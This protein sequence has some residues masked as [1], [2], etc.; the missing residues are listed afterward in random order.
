MKIYVLDQDYSYQSI[1]PIKEQLFDQLEQLGK[2]LIKN[3]ESIELKV[4]E[5]KK[6]FPRS[7]FPNLLKYVPVFSQKAKECF[8]GLLRPLGE[9]LTVTIENEDYFAYN[10]TNII[11]GLDEEQS[12]VKR[13]V[14]SG[15]IMRIVKHEFVP[16]KVKEQ[17]MFKIPQDPGSIY[18]SDLFVEK[19]NQHELVGLKFREI[20]NKNA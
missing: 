17:I 10:L 5:S 18:V 19:Y 1:A 15:R 6:E 12:E 14:S 16:E 8:Y 7:D 11:D 20:W 13:F 3:W 2:S 9:F 4:P